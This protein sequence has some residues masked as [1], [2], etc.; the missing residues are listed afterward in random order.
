MLEKY[1]FEKISR[2]QPVSA[3]GRYW[4]NKGENEID[5]NDVNKTA[6]LAEIK[7][8][9]QKIGLQALILKSA[10][11]QKHLSPYRVSFH[12]LSLNDM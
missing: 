12:A 10:A 1:F 11:I 6:Y 8:N 3:I 4:D 7:R 9:A 2:E 5:L